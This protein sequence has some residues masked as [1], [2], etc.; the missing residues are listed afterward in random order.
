MTWTGLFG[1]LSA[2]CAGLL[3][4]LAFG[5]AHWI[6]AE[7]NGQRRWM[8]WLGPLWGTVALYHAA[9]WVAD[10]YHPDINTVTLMRPCS[11]LLLA[12]PAVV[13]FRAIAEDQKHRAQQRQDTRILAAKVAEVEM[14][15]HG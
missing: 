12:I 13:L 2:A 6:H 8:I 15:L 5:Y 4:G 1:L 10:A 11:W 9:V 14:S 7:G 3:A